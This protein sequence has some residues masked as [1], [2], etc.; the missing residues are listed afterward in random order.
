[1]GEPNFRGASELPPDQ[2]DLRRQQEVAK[3]LK[4]ALPSWI[5]DGRMVSATTTDAGEVS[6]THGLKRAVK[7]WLLLSPSGSADRIC[8]VQTGGDTSVLKLKNTGATGSLAFS[9][10]VF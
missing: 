2:A 5:R 4:E 7:G 8:L 6:V 10:W 9:L 1:M 3:A